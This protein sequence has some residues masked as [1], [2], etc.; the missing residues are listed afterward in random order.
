M[1]L[2]TRCPKCATAFRV[3]PA[4][5]GARN[6]QV[7]C[8]KCNTVFDGLAAL[9]EGAQTP[10]M[11]DAVPAPA[12]ATE[13]PLPAFLAEPPRARRGPWRAPPPP[14][15]PAPAAQGGVYLPSGVVAGI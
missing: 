13:E 10:K 5:L 2:V 9:V 14:A 11:K 12:P 3:L 8:G 15:A 7:R 1:N 4:Q 6:G